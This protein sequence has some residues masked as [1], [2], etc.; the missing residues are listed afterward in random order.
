[1]DELDQALRA[2]AKCEDFSLPPAYET[3]MDGLEEQ[4]RP[5]PSQTTHT[6]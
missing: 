5:I 6:K 3:A 1:M 2:M 4:A